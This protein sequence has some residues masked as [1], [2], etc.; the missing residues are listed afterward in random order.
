MN[1][2]RPPWDNI[3]ARM[4]ISKAIDR[5]EY[6]ERSFFGLGTPAHSAIA[7]AFGWVYQEDDSDNPQAFNLDEAK[8]LAEE[9]GISG[10]TVSLMA[11]SDDTRTRE[12]IRNMLAE[13]GI[14]VEIQPLQSA[15]LNERWQAGDFDFHINGSVVDADPDDGHWNFFHSEG[16]W[17]TYGYN[18]PEA[19]ELLARTRSTVDIEERRQAWHELEQVLQ[20]D[21]AYAF[22]SHTP[23]LVAFRNAIKGYRPI[24]EIRYM[25]TVWIDE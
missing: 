2:E 18:S 22:L 17:N 3:T 11:L 25:E 24:P 12:V 8:A 7:P 15:A 4:A 16:P 1:Y 14:E 20:A 5:Q 19:D 6:I 13:I 9:A 23:D 10:M 21:V